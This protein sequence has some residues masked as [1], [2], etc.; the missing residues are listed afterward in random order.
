MADTEAAQPKQ[1]SKKHLFVRD[2]LFKSEADEFFKR[3]LS[4][5]GYWFWG[6]YK[7]IF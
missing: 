2:G 6:F 3:E 5:D 7:N 1:I 4:E